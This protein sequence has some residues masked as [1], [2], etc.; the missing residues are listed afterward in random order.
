MGSEMCIRDRST[1]KTAEL[2]RTYLDWIRLPRDI[3][4]EI[5]KGYK[6]K[7]VFGRKEKR[8]RIGGKK[9]SLLQYG[10]KQTKILLFPSLRP[11]AKRKTEEW[12]QGIPTSDPHLLPSI[13]I[14][15]N[16]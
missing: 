7:K 14:L 15:V 3:V 6:L 10:G 4:K 2:L 8:K 9:C 13:L 1:F 5:M 16:E 12:E 11:N